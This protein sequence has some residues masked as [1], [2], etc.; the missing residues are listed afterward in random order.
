MLI[1]F[2]HISIAS[3][4]FYFLTIYG[5]VQLF[6]LKDFSFYG[7]SDNKSHRPLLPLLFI[8]HRLMINQL[9]A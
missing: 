3:I 8:L 4:F 2:S 5:N 7:G 1:N 9:L 6:D